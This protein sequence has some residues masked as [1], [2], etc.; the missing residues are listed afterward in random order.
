MKIVYLTVRE[1][2]PDLSNPTERIKGWKEVLNTLAMTYPDR[3]TRPA[4]L[5]PRSS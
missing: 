2:R 5:S 4:E 3:L 1:G